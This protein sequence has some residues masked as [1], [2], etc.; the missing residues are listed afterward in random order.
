[1]KP[2]NQT[3][4]PVNQAEN[5]PLE[6]ELCNGSTYYLPALAGDLYQGKDMEAAA[7]AYINEMREDGGHELAACH[8]AVWAEFA[9]ALAAALAETRK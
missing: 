2:V 1:M 3:V 7:R 5:N 9:A 4:P 8:V 6:I